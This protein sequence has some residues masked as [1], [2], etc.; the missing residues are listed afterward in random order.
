MKLRFY[1]V[2]AA[3]LLVGV[4]AFAQTTGTLTGTATLGGNPLPGVTVTVS[5]PS[6]I[7]TRTTVT[8]S[9]GNFTIGAIPPGEYTIKFEMESM[10]TVTRTT[11]VG[12]ATTARVDAE[13][14]LTAVAEA[15]TVTASAP[16]VLETTEVQT[17]ITSQLVSNLPMNRDLRGTVGLA[18]GV[19]STGP[20]NAQVISGAPSFDN[21]Y[22]IDGAVVNENLRGQP[23]DLFIEDAIQETTVLTGGISAEFGR[24][25]GGVVTAVS[26]TG[27]NEFSGSFRDSFQS[28]KW[29]ALSPNSTAR[30]TKNINQTYEATLGGRIIRDRLWFFT[31][32]R[33]F[34]TNSAS[35][36]FGAGAPTVPTSREQQRIE[37]KL[38]GQV[39]PKHSL[40]VSSL[41]IKDDQVNNFFP[42]AARTWEVRSVDPGRSLPNSFLTAH[43]NGVITNSFLIEG[44]YAKKKFAFEQSGGDSRDLVLGTNA[45]DISGN[46]FGAPTFCGVCTP[47]SR[48]NKNWQ[49]KGTYYLST[50]GTGTHNLVAGY[51]DWVSMRKSDNH[52]SGSDFTIGMY[53]SPTATC[54]LCGIQRQGDGS[55]RITTRP[56]FD[57]IIIWWPILEAS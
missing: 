39:T 31:A 7:G 17:N 27:G 36:L 48:D 4:S 37:V 49:A 56:G 29:T 42:S 47:E 19:T 2:L 10:Q 18:P 52:Q 30:R 38:T 55:I 32:G 57:T 25:T 24:F 22:M 50:K 41:D 1:V 35:P 16:A 13:L 54:P 21:L 11:R 20:G 12:L 26:K 15:I 53:S 40:T 44:L 34:Q 51:D 43:Y 23:H 3:V 28:P 14:K 6:L 45:N 5:S 8:D 46:F 33:Y 9:N